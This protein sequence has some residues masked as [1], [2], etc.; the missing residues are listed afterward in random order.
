MK[1]CKPAENAEPCTAPEQDPHRIE[2]EANWFAMNYGS[3][4][5]SH[6]DE[7]FA[8]LYFGPGTPIKDYTAALDII[9]FIKSKFKP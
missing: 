9:E 3:V 2:I 4:K 7:L 1:K 6:K 5:L 8:A